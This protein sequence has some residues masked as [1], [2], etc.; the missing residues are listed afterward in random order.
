[1][2]SPRDP[3]GRPRRA[4]TDP[5][6][7]T[8]RA[9]FGRILDYYN[10]ASNGAL[11]AAAADL[12]GSTSLVTAGQGFAGGYYN[13]A[14]NPGSRLLAT[15]GICEDDTAILLRL[16]RSGTTAGGSSYGARSWRRSVTSRPASTPLRTRSPGA[17]EGP[18]RPIVRLPHAG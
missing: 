4:G 10:R 15:G 12:L 14:A 1:M 6:S 17:G 3:P 8:L 2:R 11:F 16:A 7:T 18:Y 13:A 9:E 5:G